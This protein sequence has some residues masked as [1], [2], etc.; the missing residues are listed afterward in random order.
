MTSRGRILAI[1]ALLG[2]CSTAGPALASRKT[3][4]KMT[5]A[6]QVARISMIDAILLAEAQTR[7]KAYKVELKRKSDGIYYEVKLVVAGDTMTIKIDALLPANAEAARKLKAARKWLQPAAKQTPAPVP[8]AA[9]KPQPAP[10]P[11]PAAAAAKPAPVAKPAPPVQSAPEP[12]E[13]PKPAAEKLHRW[14]FDAVAPDRLP[15]GWTVAETSGAGTPATW[16]VVADASAPSKPHVLAMTE[17]RNSGRTFNMLICKGTVL[18]DLELAVKVKPIAGKE[19]QGGGVVW[20]YQD[21]NN[22][23]IARWNP[24]EDNFRVYRV[25]DGRRKRLGTADVQLDPAQWHE[26]RIVMRGSKIEAYLDGKRLIKLRDG[27]F[28]EAGK[29]GLWTKADARTAFDDFVAVN[30]AGN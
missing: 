9:P 4:E 25:K 11:K 28:S 18:K 3:A 23:Y 17:N 1:V 20:R 5:A 22:Y 15:A 12:A 10:E 16:R 19:D 21:E 29:I 24:L 14:N 8:P 27:T 13:A 26:V 7:G 6:M 2:V 30:L